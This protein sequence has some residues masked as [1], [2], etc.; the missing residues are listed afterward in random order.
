MVAH[1]CYNQLIK[2]EFA[3][4]Y[5]NSVNKTLYI[6]LYGKSCVSKKGLFLDDKKA[7]EIWEAEGFA[8]KGK[9]AS[10]WLA[11][12]MGIRSAVFDEWLNQRM[13]D[14]QDAVVIHIGCGMDSRV[15]RIGTDNHKWYDVDFAEVIDE[16]RKYYSETADYQMIAG[17]ARDCR[18]L[19]AIRET[20]SAI[21]VMEGVSM[22]LTVDEMRNLTDNLCTHFES[23]VLLTDCYTAF[24][25][26]MSKHR[27][28]VNDVGVTEVYGIDGPQS[29][30]G[31]NLAFVKEHTMIP[32]KYIDELK[33]FDKLV[34]AKLYA[35]DFSKKLYRLFEYKKK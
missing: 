10:K 16:R 1:L 31:E 21:V 27:N 33:G 32:R 22:Y 8:L 9:A 19:A 7:E 6:P 17:D 13:T 5:M 30:R 14:L 3:G 28:P 23:L 2:S 4:A 15:I 26:K 25:A 11:Y 35:G 24:A 29:Y 12:Y 34:F 18:W 20:H